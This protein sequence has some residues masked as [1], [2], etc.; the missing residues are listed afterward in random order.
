MAPLLHRQPFK[1]IYLLG[2]LVVTSFQ[3]PCWLIY[4]SWRPNRPRKSWTLRRA[5]NVRIMRNVTQLL[6]LGVTSG[7]DL[8]LEV[9]QKEDRKSVV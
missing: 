6:K 3:L 1:A 4:Y 8:S 2:F 7:R 9:P 5:I